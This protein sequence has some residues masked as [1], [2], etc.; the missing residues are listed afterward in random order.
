MKRTIATPSLAL[1]AVLL[2]S[3]AAVP[4]AN[5]QTPQDPEDRWM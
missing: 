3:F 5:D 1:V 2:L 4:G